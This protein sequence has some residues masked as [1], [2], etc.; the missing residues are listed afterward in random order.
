[1]FYVFDSIDDFNIWHDAIMEEL[2]IPDELG[3]V[4]Y[5]IPVIHPTNGKV[6]A[7]VDH[8]ADVTGRISLTREEMWEEGYEPR[9]QPTG[10]P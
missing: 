10:L 7:T 6:V 8:R 9:P 2:G 3:T 4:T 5:T 1:M